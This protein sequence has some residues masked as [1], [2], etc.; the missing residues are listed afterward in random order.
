[1]RKYAFQQSNQNLHL[2]NIR[3]QEKKYAYH[4]F[5]HSLILFGIR[6]IPLR[7]LNNVG[8]YFLIDALSVL[9]SYLYHGQFTFIV[10]LQQ[11]QHYYYVL[12]WNK[13]YWSK[14]VAYWSSLDWH[15][16]GGKSRA[17]EWIGTFYDVSTHVLM[18]YALSEYIGFFDYL[19]SAVFLA[20]GSKAVLFNS[21]FAWSSPSNP[22]NW[23]KKRATE[24]DVY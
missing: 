4:T 20:I 10:I 22:P 19:V 7:D 15:V 3:F 11:I 17:L 24:T 16:N 18:M 23:V 21:K 1:M 12:T 8:L 9:A 5:A 6:T 14:R 2:G 13:S